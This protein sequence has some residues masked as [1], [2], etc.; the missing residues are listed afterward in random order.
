MWNASMYASPPPYCAGVPNIG[1]QNILV[2]GRGISLFCALF[3]GQTGTDDLMDVIYQS[4]GNSIIYEAGK[5]NAIA[6]VTFSM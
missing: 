2:Y 6:F 5:A 3:K 4:I 1:V